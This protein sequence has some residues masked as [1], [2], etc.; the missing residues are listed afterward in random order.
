MPIGGPISTAPI[1]ALS[2][3]ISEAVGLASGTGAAT[4]TG[5]AVNPTIVSGVGAATGV[6]TTSAVGFANI[7][8]AVGLATGSGAAAAIAPVAPATFTTTAVVGTKL[9]IGGHDAF[10][11]SPDSAPWVEVGN[12]FHIGPYLGLDFKAINLEAIGD[13]YTRK[14][15]GSAFARP[16]DLVINRDDV[17]L[18]QIAL[19]AAL[20]DRT[21]TY[22]FKIEETD[23]VTVRARTFFRG[24]VFAFATESNDD[25]NSVK[26]INASI[27]VNPS[28]IINTTL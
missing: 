2:E 4:A 15:K 26:H 9:Y 5:S 21:F 19:K 11:I 12:L 27:E 1:S 22:N 8:A 25:V 23:G 24:Q 10:L 7:I 17:D 14:L 3:S 18:G 20:P 28:T 16:L 6:G 13:G